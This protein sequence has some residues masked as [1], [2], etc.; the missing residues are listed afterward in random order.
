MQIKTMMR[1]HF[2]FTGMAIIE[3]RDNNKYWW[4][5]GEI[6]ILIYSGGNVK[7]HSHCENSPAAPQKIKHTVAL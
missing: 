5:C 1:Y 2:A 4:G 3:K 6:E 7:G